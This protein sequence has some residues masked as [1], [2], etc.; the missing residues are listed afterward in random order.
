MEKNANIPNGQFLAMQNFAMQI[1]DQEK[2]N[3]KLF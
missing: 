1:K 3:K 2:C